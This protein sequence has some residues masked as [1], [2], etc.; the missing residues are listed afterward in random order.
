MERVYIFNQPSFNP[1]PMIK[2]GVLVS[3]RGSNLEA[4]IRNIESGK[5]PAEIRIVISD[6]PDAQALEK[7]REHRIEAIYLPPGKYK[8][9]LD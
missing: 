7:A 2:L 9:F 6:I 3:G 1:I 8:T 4:I 5:L